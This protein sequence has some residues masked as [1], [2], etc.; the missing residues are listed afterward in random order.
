[1][2]E[3]ILPILVVVALAVWWFGSHSLVGSIAQTPETE[4]AL[5][6]VARL[7]AQALRAFDI[8]P[9]EVKP[10][11]A[12]G[13]PCVRVSFAQAQG[14]D[15]SGVMRQARKAAARTLEDAIRA[16]PVF[17]HVASKYSG[18]QGLHWY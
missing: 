17:A 7:V 9:H 10:V 1:V 13:C 18:E 16:S 5:E 15:A 3:Y 11:W 12:H 6:D 4:A 8:G 14:N 2:S